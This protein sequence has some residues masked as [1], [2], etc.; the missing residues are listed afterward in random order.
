MGTEVGLDARKAEVRRFWEVASRGQE[1]VEGGTAEEKHRK[2]AEAR[3]RPE[4]YIRDFARFWVGFGR[5]I[6]EIRVGM[7]A[8]H[9]EWA[10]SGLRHLAGIDLTLRAETRTAKRLDACDLKSDLREGDAEMSFS[11]TVHSESSTPGSASP[12]TGH[13]ASFL[14]AVD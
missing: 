9:L 5:D 13:A 4:P 7:S 11:Q 8:D 14:E 10:R 2:H 3:Y 1:Y 12:F 6:L